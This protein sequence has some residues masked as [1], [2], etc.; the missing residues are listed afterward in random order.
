MSE[1]VV[2]EKLDRIFGFLSRV[3]EQRLLSPSVTEI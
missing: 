2:R 3:T 1:E